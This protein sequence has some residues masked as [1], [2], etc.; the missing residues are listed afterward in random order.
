MKLRNIIAGTCLFLAFQSPFS[1]F[2]A[3][4]HS[5]VIK[6]TM[7]SGGYTYMLVDNKDKETWVAIPATTVK[8]GET[9]NYQ[10]GVTM[11]K[12]ASKT[13]NR[14]FD[15]IVF[16][17]GLANT[18]P[19]EIKQSK[20][21]MFKSA[22]TKEQMGTITAS[23][24]SG[25]SSGSVTSFA[26]LE[27]TKAT[28]ENSYSISELYADKDKL[29]GQTILLRGKVMKINEN[30]MGK[31]WIHLQDGTGDPMKNSHDLVLTGQIAP[32]LGAIVTVQGKVAIN[33]DFGYSYKYDLLLEEAK[34]VK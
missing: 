19:T 12:F 25:G 20:D 2:A 1:S 4:S 17:G 15:S 30:I 23:K 10:H 14:S 6:E 9:V 33:K 7:N 28:G 32:E 26:D 5:G 16:S 24:E 21:E 3:D 22:I 8:V 29:S 34:L 18:K 11:E 31:N 27:I 13:L